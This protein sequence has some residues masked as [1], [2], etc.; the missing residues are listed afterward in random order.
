MEANSLEALEKLS[1]I[2]KV[3]TELKNHGYGETDADARLVSEFIIGLVT[4][5]PNIEKFSKVLRNQANIDMVFSKNIYNLIVN[6][7]KFAGRDKQ[8]K[9][10]AEEMKKNGDIPSGAYNPNQ[11]KID[12]RKKMFPGLC[13]ADDADAARK[14]LGDID[15]SLTIPEDGKRGRDKSKK[16]DRKSSSESKST[17]KSKKSSTGE[18]EADDLMAQLEKMQDGGKEEEKE[19][20]RYRKEKAK[21]DAKREYKNEDEYEKYRY[22]R[23]RHRSSDGPLDH[24]PIIGKIYQGRVTNIKVFGAFVYLSGIEGKMEGLIHLTELS[25]KRIQDP[26]TIVDRNQD[27]FVKILSVTGKRISLSYKDVDQD[28]GIDLDPS[29]MD[30]RKELKEERMEKQEQYMREAVNLENVSN[31]RKKKIHGVSDMERWELKQIMMGGG[32]DRSLMPDF[33]D[34]QGILM[35]DPDSD[36][37]DL[38]IDII[39]EEPPFLA[40]HDLNKARALSPVRIVKNP[41]G[42]LSQAAQ[43]QGELSKDRRDIKRE[44]RERE[45]EEMRLTEASQR[46]F[47]DPMA[48]LVETA[49]GTNKNDPLGRNNDKD[50]PDWK[51]A[52]LGVSQSGAHKQLAMGPRSQNKTIKQQR[53]G[54]PIF[55]LRDSLLQAIHDNQLLIVIGET[56][57]GKTT[58]ITQYLAEDGWTARGKIACTQPRRVA[59]MSVAQ[60]V[61]EEYGT[62][63]GQD[64]GYTIRFEDCTCTDTIIKY[65]TDG[66]L[67]RE[68]LID[69]DLTQ[70]SIIMLDEAHERT[71]HTDVLFGL[72][73]KTVKRR[74]DLKLIITSATLDA[75]KF[76]QYFF[77]APIFTIP[78]RTHP[79]EV[80]YTKEPESDYVDA[81]LITVM[82]IHLNEPPGDVL[83]FFTG[84]EEIDTAC[85]ILYERMRALGSDVPEMVI[86]PVYG[87][88][89]SEMQTKIFDPAPKG[90]R[91]IIIA[92]NIA[93]TSLTID[94]IYFVVDP[95]F[96]KQNV[97]NA[98]NGVDQL[99]VT[100]I[101]QAQ[102][103][104]R[105]GRAGRTGPGKCYRLYTERAYNDEMLQT[106]VPELQ[107]TNLA[108]TVL[109]LKAMGIN[110]LLQFDFMDPP[111]METLISAMQSLYHLGALDEEGL[112]TKLG[113]RM[114]EFPLEPQL[115]KVLIMSVHLRC[116]DEVLTIVSM[117]SVQNVF[118]RPK[119]KQQLADQRKAKFN[120]PEGDHLTLLA[121]FNA[122][123]HSKFSDP[124]CFD[125]FVQARTLKRSSDIRKQLLGIM[126]RHK[127]DIIT[128]GNQVAQVQKCILSGFFTKCA[129]RD[130]QEGYRT[131]V[132]QQVVFIHPSSAVF[133]RQ[134]D[135]VIYHELVL[136]TKEY[137]R[138]VIAIDPKWLIELAPN[139]FKAADSTRL[140]KYKKNMTLNPLYRK[141]EK[142]GEW[143]ISKAKGYK[144]T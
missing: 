60:R 79:V 58:Q 17:K 22:D 55:Q 99:V 116:S 68:C 82:Q 73:K 11:E 140:S 47:N 111:P 138:E 122:W 103:K 33:D 21:K 124:W 137:M 54:L 133:Q 59:A 125:N 36:A 129:K 88:L 95:G 96:V 38:E 80:L 86:L 4:E 90:T 141:Y 132:D 102:A 93:E 119:E 105:S 109:S 112:L 118:Y 30:R 81:A 121:V 48:P 126:D 57:S 142:P 62:R 46:N 56:G 113:R 5:V 87:A 19:H 98:K 1:I 61:S 107:R 136:T 108:S 127:L 104:Q 89:P 63:V 41:D 53:E 44:R 71:I 72:L 49:G 32:M 83:L 85:E 52:I 10:E 65:M 74:K 24:A 43:K 115:S 91:K 64:V 67:L 92:T 37:E 45:L 20:E 66:M 120:Q 117:L 7:K 40:G 18:V 8:A 134:P 114:A 123:K 139:F 94:G 3:A 14:L 84:Q 2:N 78:G 6:M 29:R 39:E 77:E 76:S 42:S 9:K 130:A 144:P 31:A 101:S 135:W 34:Q 27:V 131:L 128:C 28:T 51:K 97:Y 26:G 35:E 13:R 16:S 70:Y 12:K 69:A 23:K 75:V 15:P 50:L 100:P 106:N 143:R 25:K 110:D